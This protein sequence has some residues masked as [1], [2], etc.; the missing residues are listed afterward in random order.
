MNPGPTCSACAGTVMELSF[1][2]PLRE[3]QREGASDDAEVHRDGGVTPSRSPADDVSSAQQESAEKRVRARANL[4]NEKGRCQLEAVHEVL[5]V[6]HERCFS[7]YRLQ[8]WVTGKRC[9]PGSRQTHT[10]I[11]AVDTCHPHKFSMI[12]LPAPRSS[13]KRA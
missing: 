9:H 8:R 12:T 4:G 5:H 6:C 3:Q 13:P 1:S 10:I 2:H 11:H 7:I